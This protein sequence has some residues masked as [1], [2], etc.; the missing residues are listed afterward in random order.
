MYL[1]FQSVF[2]SVFLSVFPSSL[3]MLY[4]S[5]SVCMLVSSF[6]R[7]VRT[8]A[9]DLLNI[10]AILDKTRPPV[11]SVPLQ[12]DHIFTVVMDTS[13]HQGSAVTL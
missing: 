3:C 11:V 10:H 8:S 5:L 7:L 1:Y 4:V 13:V 2:L 12:C 6:V 9:C